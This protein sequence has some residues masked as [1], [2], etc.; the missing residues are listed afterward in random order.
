MTTPLFQDHSITGYDQVCH[1][2]TINAATQWG[3]DPYNPADRAIIIQRLA[4]WVDKLRLHTPTPQ[5][6]IMESDQPF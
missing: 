4:T 6:I 2:L 1:Q 5:T 3:L